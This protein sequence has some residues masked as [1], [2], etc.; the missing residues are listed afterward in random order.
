MRMKYIGAATLVADSY[1][2]GQIKIKKNL[3]GLGYEV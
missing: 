2:N 3:S 1:A